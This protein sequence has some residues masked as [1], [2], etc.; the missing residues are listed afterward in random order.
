M[1]KALLVKASCLGVVVLMGCQTNNITKVYVAA[2]GGVSTP[3]GDGGAGGNGGGS[4]GTVT[5]TGGSGTGGLG[6]G[7]SGT[8]GSGTGGSGT[9]GSGTGGSILPT[10]DGPFCVAAP[11][12][13]SRCTAC[14]R[15]GGNFP[16]LTVDGLV[17]LP[18][19]ASQ[20]HPDR[21][22][23]DPGNPNGSLLIRRVL[24]T[25]SPDEGGIMPA[26]GEIPGNEQ[27]ALVAWVVAGA[28]TTCDAPIP[29][30]SP[31][32]PP[33]AAPL[34]DAALPVGAG[35][36]CQVVPVLVSQCTACHRPGGNFPDLTIAALPNVVN[37][38]SQAHAGRPLVVPGNAG[39]SLL[40]RKMAGTQAADEGGLMPPGH[41][42]SAAQLS[43]VEDWIVAQAP[44]T[45]DD[46]QGIPDAG[47]PAN[48][49]PA[50]YDAPA[51]HGL[52]LKTGAQ[53]C[54]QCHGN[55]LEG[56]SG[57][58]CDSCH[59]A[60]WRTNC[61]YCHGGTDS[62]T[63]APP[64]DLRGANA[65]AQLS[66]AAHT[67]H[68]SE[69][70]HIAWDCN[71]CHTKPMDVLSAGHV[72]D[73]TP[74]VAE[75]NFAG[76]LSRGGVY[77]G[78]GQCDNLYCHGTGRANGSYNDSRATPTCATCHPNAGLQGRHRNHLGEATCSECHG[79]TLNNNGTIGD[80]ALHVNG[81]IDVAISA[82]GFSFVGGTC[83]GTCHGEGHNGRRW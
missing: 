80:I 82:P 52:E 17:Q 1:K 42:V 3:V 18:G 27:N 39:G 72:F 50:G 60:G 57:P 51:V 74:G 65:A 9:G 4:G 48:Y 59:Q 83:N 25:Q 38:D 71:Q 63:G 45:C 44:T 26:A 8:G 6:T 49:H 56:G 68:Q 13:A 22:L 2:D 15:P 62:D 7:G 46:P 32:V 14:H 61:T 54:R 47:P 79:D 41:A 12:F 10:G 11:V 76:G 64:R 81:H 69:N 53:D 66:F 28:P 24:G 23:V 40:Y 70:N 37:L 31:I 16:D 29:D 30:A 19:L 78:N 43:L 73:N 75:V 20:Q 34:P 67:A 77:S 5:G 36:Y 35:P 33:D 21:L 58:S 55:T